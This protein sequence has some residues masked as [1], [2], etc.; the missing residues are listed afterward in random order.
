MDAPVQ[1]PAYLWFDLEFSSL[2]VS[3]ARI[4]QAALVI[5]DTRL[6]R[7]G[8]PEEDI[9]LHVQL[10]P[11]SRVSPWVQENLAPVL[12][13]CRSPL[14]V[15]EDELDRRLAEA[16]DRVLGSPSQE[17]AMRPVLAG[18]SVHM[19]L[20]LARRALPRF[21]QRLHYRLLDVSAVKVLW[22]D[23][24]AGEPFDKNSPAVIRQY[25][26]EAAIPAAEAAIHDAYYDVQASIAELAFYLRRLRIQPE[27][28]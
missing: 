16:V 5:T 17:M 28:R 20:A 12:A 23:V 14:A 10:P 7:L 22:Q 6:R 1:T 19:D 2:D 9:H 3:R 27:A 21:A 24:W 11:G 15:R 26:P 8:P 13:A 25:F 4:L 18:N